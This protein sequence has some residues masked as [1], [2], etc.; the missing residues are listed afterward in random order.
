MNGLECK[1]GVCGGVFWVSWKVE[2]C[3]LI[4]VFVIAVVLEENTSGMLSLLLQPWWVGDLGYMYVYIIYLSGAK[5]GEVRWIVLLETYWL[6][7]DFMDEVVPNLLNKEPL[8][9]QL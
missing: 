2:G 6:L 8:K 3:L 5:R 7:E 1:E 9:T 4:V